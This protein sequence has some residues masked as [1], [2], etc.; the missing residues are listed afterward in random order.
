MAAPFLGVLLLLLLAAPCPGKQAWD[1]VFQPSF[2]LMSGP[3]V[4]SFFLGNSSGVNFSIILSP[5]DEE[6][7][8]LQLANCS[9]SKRA[10]DWNLN[11]TPGMNTSKVTISLTRNL[12]LCLP[13]ATDC[14]TTPLCVVETLQVLAC[15]DSVMLAHL[16]IQ[17]EIYANSSFT[18]NVSENATIIPN[19]VFQPLGSCPCDLTAGAC[20]VRCCCDPECTP[21]LK[22]LFNESCFT[23]VFGGDVNPPFD[24]LCSSRSMEYTPDWFPFLCVQSSLNNT[25]FLGYFYH[26]SLSIPRVPPFKIP[27]QTS[28]GKHFT[29]YCQ[30]NPIMTEENEYFTIPQQSMAGQCVGNAPVAYLQNFDVKCLTHLA[31]YKEGLPHDVR[32]NSGTGDFIQQNVIYRT[33]TDMGKFITESESLHTAEVLCQNVTFAE[34]YMFIWKDKNIEQ[35]NVTVF[36]GSLCEGEI[37]TQRFTVNFLSLKSANVAELFGNPGYQVG[38]PVKAANMNASNIS[39]SLNIWQPAG[40]GLCTSATYTPVLFGLDSL[41]GCILEV[42]INEDCSLLRGNVTE[43]LNSLIQA[44]HIGKRDNSS[45]SDLNDWVEIIRLDPFNSE[46]NVSRGNLKGICPDIPANLNIHLIFADVGA[47]QGIPQQEILAV[48]IS[49]STVIWQFQCGLTCE[50]SVSF[51][52]ITASVQFIKVPA[53][54]PIPMTSFQINY[55]EFDC[56]RNDVCWP[57]LFYPLTRFY[58]GE[59]YSQCLAKGLSLAFVVLLAAIM[60]NPWFSKLWNSSLF[61]L[62]TGSPHPVRASAAPLPPSPPPVGRRGGPAPRKQLAALPAA[63]RGAPLRSAMAAEPRVPAGPCAPP[64]PAMGSLFRG[65]PM[66]LAQLFLQSGSAYE[67]LSEVGERGLAEFRD[68]NPNVSVFQR[69]FV[70]EVKKCEEMERILGYLVQEIKKADIPLPEGDVAPPAPL[71]KHILEIQEQLQKLETE[72]REVTKNKEKLRKNLLELTEYTCMLE[73][74]QRFVR[75][76][77]EY[78][79][80]LHTNYEEFPSVENE[81]LVDYNCMHRLGAKLGFISGLVNIAKVEAF[82]KMLWRACKGYT[83][84]TYAELDECLEDPDT[85]ETT[86][87]FVFLVSY[88]G[89]QIGQKVK[90]ICDCY[91][92]HVYPYPNTMEERKAVVEGLTVRI[93]DL[94]T[95]L[96]KTEDYLRQVLCKASESIYTWVIQV[97][98]MKAIYHVLNLCSFDVTNKCLIAEAWCPVADLQNLRHALEEGSRKSGATISSFMNTIPTTQPPPTLIRTNK[99]TSGFQNIVDAYGVGNYGEVN[100]ALYTIITFPFLFAV[101]F[102]DFGH[103]LLMFIFALL[104]ILYENHPR[105]KRSQDE[106]MKMFFEGRYVILLMGLFSVYTGL[107]YNDCFSKSLNIFGSGWNVSAMFEQ[108]VWRLEDLKSNQFLTLDPNV[109]GVYNG[110]YPFG[111]DPIWNLAS[112]RLSFLNSFKMKMSVI[113]GVTHMTFGVVLGVFNH[114]HFK[115]KYNIYLVFLPELLF[116][117]CI[118]G[119][120]VFMIFFKWL[121]YSAEDSTSA[122]SI[123]IQFINMFLFPGGETEVFY[124]GQIALQR[125]LLSIAFLSVPVM[126]F[127]KPLYLYWLHSGG[128]GIR[129][130]RSGYKLIRKE[131]E[132]ELSLL[133]SHDVEEGSLSDSVHRDGDGE[134]LNFADVFMNQA[135]HTIEYCLGCISNTASYLRLW[136]LSLAHAQLSEVLWQMVMRVG[137]RVDTTYGVLLLVPVLAFFAVLTVLILLVMEGLS[138]FL[139][140]IRLHWVEFQNKF[141]SGGGYKFTPFSFK[142]ISLHFNK[143]TA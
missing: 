10:G 28:P 63:G 2:I 72:L 29:G 131:S 32:I 87:W 25:P 110:A 126:L 129:M 111:I 120:L 52:P 90:K 64:R 80:H 86:K 26:G 66:C 82:E 139:H 50:N 11:V 113:F 44:T 27:L 59:P 134:E 107:I 101:M 116:M 43:K 96:H 21:D 97:K 34:H 9:G 20:D 103:G 5:I 78:E 56:N 89:E 133:R 123:L 1:P 7:G 121:A 19:Q 84:L 100:P 45:Y 109:T 70:N 42:G 135:I 104:T 141:Y 68:L 119:Y 76:T 54:P 125:F 37:L 41:S 17:A 143:D 69:K 51:L 99:F 57:Q 118:F 75:R 38:K 60:S 93:Q 98:K 83:I 85:G 128:R 124:T 14:C 6:T 105:L 31:S 95:V 137:L 74:T 115:K 142:H 15:R 48:Q 94:H 22:Q 62:R 58:T 77:A 92:C 79:S 71:L 30:G 88:W 40:R 53:Q 8:R 47:V 136:A 49:Y 4:N 106:I 102:G 140:A 114:L 81:P 73:V 55:T 13:N 36:L 24:Q 127:G 18:G 33:V 91:H 23:G 61:G 112:N 35:I 67:C 130:Y 108:K 12:E 46:T 65:E 39:G 122:P 3:R 138:A 16:L 117:M 132:E